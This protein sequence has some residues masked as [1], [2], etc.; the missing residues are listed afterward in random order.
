MSTL[1]ELV[2]Y[3][4]ME[5]PVGAMALYGESG[6]GKT[7]LIENELSEALRDTH[8]IVRVS[9]FG[10]DSIDALH[11]AVKKQWLLMCTPF[12][13]RLKERYEHN[14]QR[15]G[16][17]KAVTSLIKKL[18][19][20]AGRIADTLS[21]PYEYIVI[22]PESFATQ[23]KERK[24]VILTF[25]DADRTRLNW[26]DLFGTI[27][28]YCENLH[29]NTIIIASGELQEETDPAALAV[30]AAAKEKTVAYMT[31]HSPDYA[32]IVHSVIRERTWK[33]AEYGRFLLDHEQTVLEL[34]ASD[35]MEAMT[36]GAELRKH[37]NI[38]CLITGMENFYRV[39]HHMTRAGVT[40]L[41][42][43]LCAFLAFH[44]CTWSGI[45]RNGKYC[46]DPADEEIRRLYPRFSADHLFESVRRW[47]SFGYW[48]KELFRKELA[49]VSPGADDSDK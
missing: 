14:E 46:D 1:E 11:T 9:L 31:I 35:P 36:R 30:N 28:D 40:D 12:L 4:R 29:F 44:L 38:R 17:L 37:H 32:K 47:I 15:K 45:T 19:P 26:T 13:T 6:C 16:I 2:H 24:K 22:A 39:Y 5:K 42:P 23:T 41:E 43:Y 27:N 7:Y 18:D 20:K 8:R 34:F 3:C 10:I 49:R 21:D 33:T 48:D 25:D